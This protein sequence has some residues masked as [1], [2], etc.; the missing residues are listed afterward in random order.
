[1]KAISLLALVVLAPAKPLSAKVSEVLK[2][3]AKYDGKAVAVKGVVA[4]FKARTSK[5]GN[6]YFVFDLVEG[7][8]HL[9]VYGQGKLQ[10]APKDG[11]KV[12]VTGKYAKERKVG[13]RT[14]KNE[15]DASTRLDKSFGVKKQ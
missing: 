7:K 8:E 9:A 6:D 14:F 4:E 2:D 15:I 5:A 11:D 12:T 10:N 3:P 1:M 13:S